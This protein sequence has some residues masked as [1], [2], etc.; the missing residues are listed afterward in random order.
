MHQLLNFR[1]LW[2]TQAIST[3]LKKIS[4]EDH[5][6]MYLVWKPEGGGEQ[7]VLGMISWGWKGTSKVLSDSTLGSVTDRG[8]WRNASVC[9]Q[10]KKVRSTSPGRLGETA[11]NCTSCG[12]SP[13][14]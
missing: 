8:A 5:F 2:G 14:W 9:P 4:G 13:P 12:I 10:D 7:E 6:E 1:H 3:M 11:M